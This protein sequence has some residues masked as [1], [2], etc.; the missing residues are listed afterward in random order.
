MGFINTSITTGS[1]KTS[2]TKATYYVNKKLPDGVLL[3]FGLDAT[4]ED[5]RRIL[6]GATLQWADHLICTAKEQNWPDDIMFKIQ[7]PD[8]DGNVET[9]YYYHKTKEREATAE[10]KAKWTFTVVA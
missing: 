8:E 1:T 9:W 6:K 3:G 2:G 10:T 5:G 7:F 4:F